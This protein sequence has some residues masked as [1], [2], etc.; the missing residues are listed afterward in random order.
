[1]EGTI[2]VK[3]TVGT[4]KFEAIVGCTLFSS[5]EWSLLVLQPEGWS[6]NLWFSLVTRLSMSCGSPGKQGWGLRGFA[7]CVGQPGLPAQL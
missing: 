2:T 1:M 3:Q 7:G 5:F 4:H 6:E